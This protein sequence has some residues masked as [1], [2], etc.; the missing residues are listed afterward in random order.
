MFAET[1]PTC[2]IVTDMTVQNQLLFWMTETSDEL[3]VFIGLGFLEGGK[4]QGRFMEDE[5]LEMI[6]KK[7][8]LECVCAHV[9]GK[10]AQ[11]R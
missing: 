1:N 4:G 10:K 3:K 9:C 6:L 8:D 11:G 2:E 5:G 7:K